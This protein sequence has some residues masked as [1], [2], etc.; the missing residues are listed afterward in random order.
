[1]ATSQISPE[2]DGLERVWKFGAVVPEAVH[3]CIQN[4]VARTVARQPNAP[5]VCAWDGELTYGELDTLAAKLASQLVKF[6]IGPG[7]VVP[8]CFEKSMWTAV[9]VL[10]VVK[11]GAGFVLLDRLLPEERLRIIVQQTHSKLILTSV[12]NGDLASQF[13]QTILLVSPALTEDYGYVLSQSYP[14]PHPSSI[15]YVVFT[16][17]STGVP[18][19]CAISHENLC[20]VLHHQIHCLGFRPSSRVFDFASYSFD[21][22]IH[23]MFAALVI[24]GCLC[25]PNEADG[26]ENL[27]QSMATMQATYVDLT[28]TVASLLNPEAVPTLKTLVLLGEMVTEC[29]SKVWWGKTQLVNAYGPTECTSLCTINY[30]ASTPTKLGSIGV[31]KGVVTWIVN[32]KDHKILLPWGQTGELLVEGPIVGLGYLNDPEKSAA[33]FIENPTSLVQGAFDVLGRGD[34]IKQATL[35]GTTKM[36]Q[37]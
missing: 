6:G 26:K 29:D 32:P 4:L 3:D 17:G 36:A 1:M 2:P 22:A 23:N 5:A 35:Y 31:G 16:S 30:T 27:E 7:D 13:S 12:L 10:G 25:V 9:A 28:P 37:L 14:T 11:A 33:V 18:K 21:V 15:K 20:S 8:L 19:G 24:G 34:C